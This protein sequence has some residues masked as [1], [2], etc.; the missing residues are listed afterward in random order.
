[1]VKGRDSPPDNWD[2]F[3]VEAA[4]QGRGG[5]L[6]SLIAGAIGSFLPAAAPILNTIADILPV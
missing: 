4:K 5:V 6:S 3:F 2:N 1:M